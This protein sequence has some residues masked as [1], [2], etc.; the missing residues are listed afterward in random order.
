MPS[1]EK[2][3]IRQVNRPQKEDVDT[4]VSWFLQ[5]FDLTARRR[6]WNL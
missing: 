5:A 3:V 6:A 4:L 2:M 1:E